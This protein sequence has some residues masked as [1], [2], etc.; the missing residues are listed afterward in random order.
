MILDLMPPRMNGFQVC[1]R[2]ARMRALL[3][4]GIEPRPAQRRC[5]RGATPI[6]LAAKQFSVLARLGRRAN[7]V[8]S[9][10][11]ILDEVWEA[12]Y[13]G[14]LNIVEVCIRA[15]RRVIDLPFGVHGIETVRG[16]GYR[17]VCADA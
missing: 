13:D 15:L 4:R 17:L 8:V 11:E 5:S 10:A 2:L 6:A 1:A 14:D 9:K 12:A 3:R 16:A 7:A